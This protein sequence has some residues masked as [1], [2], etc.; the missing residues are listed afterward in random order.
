MII[1]SQSSTTIFTS[2]D[3]PIVTAVSRRTVDRALMTLEAIFE[4]IIAGNIEESD[5]EVQATAI[6]K[7]ET[8]KGRC[9]C[10]NLTFE[11]FEPIEAFCQS[12]SIFTLS[13]H[14]QAVIRPV[15]TSHSY[16]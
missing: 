14:L 13:I 1:D 15:I 3:S 9:K 12:L 7:H 5:I 4:E 2:V 6:L 8:K 10:P 16:I 11:S